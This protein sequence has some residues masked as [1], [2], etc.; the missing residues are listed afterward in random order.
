MQYFLGKSL[1][2]KEKAIQTADKEE[3]DENEGIKAK[4]DDVFFFSLV[5]VKSRGT[6]EDCE[7][8]FDIYTKLYDFKA[9]N[10][11][12]KSA[13]DLGEYYES[14]NKGCDVKKIDIYTLVEYFVQK[15]PDAHYVLDE[16]PFIQ[17]EKSKCKIYYWDYF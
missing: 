14:Q 4:A 8:I 10:V 13:Q 3:N 16:V 1:I 9:C 11:H 12:I 15:N 6:V 2:C 7:H 5:G 17:P